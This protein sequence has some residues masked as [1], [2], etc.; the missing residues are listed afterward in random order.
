[1]MQRA[2]SWTLSNPSGGLP[3]L[4]VIWRDDID[5]EANIKA[6]YETLP[7]YRKMHLLIRFLMWCKLI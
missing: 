6:M 7:P 1:M 5:E 3:Y 2:R 4:P